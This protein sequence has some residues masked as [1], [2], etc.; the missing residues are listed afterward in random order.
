MHPVTWPGDCGC[1]HSPGGHD[2]RMMTVASLEITVRSKK[3]GQ[4]QTAGPE[5]L[6]LG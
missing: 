1:H 4:V 3:V 6:W 5:C 2:R